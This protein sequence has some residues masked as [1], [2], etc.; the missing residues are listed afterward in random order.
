MMHPMRSG[1]S[2]M[3]VGGLALSLSGCGGDDATVTGARQP[4]AMSSAGGRAE[5]SGDRGPSA[6][7]A[8]CACGA[9]TGAVR[10]PLA[11]FCAD[12]ANAELCSLPLA[13]YVPPA[14]LC[15]GGGP[16]VVRTT[17]CGRVSFEP[18]GAFAGVTTIFDGTS[19]SLVGVLK[20]NDIPVEACGSWSAL[21]GRGLFPR[22]YDPSLPSLSVAA[23]VC[24]DVA[25]CTV[26]GS[27]EGNPAACP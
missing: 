27:T 8:S 16:A 11:C 25:T 2:W 23:D 20:F 4:A 26:C 1:A 10:L 21:F 9:A 24:P 19:G 15:G 13:R 6:A 14:E 7:E 18:Q 12:P 3:A 22:A 5:G 17:G